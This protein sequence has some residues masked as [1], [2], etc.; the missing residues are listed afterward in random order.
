MSINKHIMYLKIVQIAHQTCYK[1]VYHK[2]IDHEK[3]F[4]FALRESVMRT[5]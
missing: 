1:Q 4:I 2:N 5:N 3:I